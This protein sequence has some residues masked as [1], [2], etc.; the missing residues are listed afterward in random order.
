MNASTALRSLLAIIGGTV[1]ITISVEALE[2]TLVTAINRGPVTDPEAYYAVRNGMAFLL[3][4][5]LY[6]TAAAVAGGYVAARIAGRAEILHGLAVAAI[7]T[8]SFVWAVFQPEMRRWTPMWMWITLMFVSAIG[9][10]YG[11]RLA[12]ERR[13]RH[14]GS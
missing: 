13:L 4:K 7:Q 5:L 11:A 9:I 12:G 14:E 8:G 3:V 6:N 10:I 1:F 2:W